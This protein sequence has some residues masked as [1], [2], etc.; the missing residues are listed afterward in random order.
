MAINALLETITRLSHEFG[1]ADFVKGGGGNTS[2]KTA[3]TLYVKPSGVTLAGLTP[4]GFVAMDRAKL[5]LLF[6]AEPPRE[7]SAR[8]TLVKE[9]M[10]ASVL[11]GFTGRPSVEAPLHD[12]FRA[13]Y[14]V[15]THPATVNGL[16]CA[17]NGEAACRELFPGALWMDYIDPGYTLCMAVRAAI[18]DY[19]KKNGAEPRL[20]FLKNHGVF[21]AGDTA[22][23]IRERYRAVMD[24]LAGVY[25]KAGISP[26]LA[27]PPPPSDDETKIIIEKLRQAGGAETAGVAVSG[28]FR[29]AADAISP[30]HIV[31]AKSFPWTGEI[32]AAAFQEYKARRGY[33]PRVYTC[34]SAVFGLGPTQKTADLALE[35]AQDGAL[36]EQMANAFGGIRYLDEKARLFIENWEVESYRQKVMES[37]K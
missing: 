27:V 11:P 1:S 5:G 19:E 33:A 32:S 13:T 6:T 31:Y 9:M 21:I 36:V 23:E 12:T 25:A 24:T 8:E 4:A 14:V 10:A 28:P 30:D 22:E 7:P 35:F 18:Q 29:V 37:G 2:A 16:T 20:V 17:V 3:E 15:H 26:A 34:A